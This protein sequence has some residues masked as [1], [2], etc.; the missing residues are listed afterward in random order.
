MPA[1]PAAAAVRRE[2]LRI[3]GKSVTTTAQSEVFNP[4]SRALV[5][6][7]AR[8]ALADVRHAIAV[9]KAC[10]PRLT[11]YERYRICY[12]TAE[13]LRARTEQIAE[14][15]TAESGLCKKDSTYEVG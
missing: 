6:T 1:E 10:R 5:G 3:G 13:L 11:R 14:L 8:A 12:R 7:V 15:I 4:Y 9:A 2:G